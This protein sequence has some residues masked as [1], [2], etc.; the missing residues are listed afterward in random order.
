MIDIQTNIEINTETNT[1]ANVETICNVIVADD[2]PIILHGIRT[3][4]E[5]DSNICIAGTAKT[6]TELFTALSTHACDL[7]VCDYSFYGDAQPDG[8]PMIQKIRQMYPSV[9]IIVLSARDDLATALSALECGVYAFVRKNSDMANLLTA[10][11]EV[12]LGNKFTD[13]ATSQD[14]LKHMLSLS[15]TRQPAALLR[16]NFGPQEI[17]TMRLLQRGLSL[18]D[19]ALQTNRSVK[20]VSAQKQLIMK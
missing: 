13:T 10:L 2:H 14:I 18:T 20:T 4:L 19:I 1:E 15:R 16:T 3:I 8:L 11:E 7:L 12:R 5:A 17:E 6:V 9:R